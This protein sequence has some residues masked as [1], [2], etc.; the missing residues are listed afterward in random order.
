MKVRGTASTKAVTTRGRKIEFAG[1]WT[2][3]RTAT[4]RANF[5]LRLTGLEDQRDRGPALRPDSGRKSQEERHHRREEALLTR[6][7]PSSSTSPD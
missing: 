7:M 2:T 6:R 1:S 4:Q 3:G 5:P